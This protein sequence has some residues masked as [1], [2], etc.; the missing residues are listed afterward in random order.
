MPIQ[1]QSLTG[2][3]LADEMGL[4]KT[5]EILA[6]IVI[7]RRSGEFT[8]LKA[9]EEEANKKIV[10]TK[11]IMFSCVCGNK[12]ENFIE[13]VE[14]QSLRDIYQCILCKLWMHNKCVNYSGSR[15]TFI[16]LPC[17]DKIPPISSSCTLIVTPSIISS[18]WIEEI[19]KHLNK[20]LNILFYN[21]AMRG[22]IQPRD[23]A[24]LDICITTYDVLNDELAHVFAIENAKVLR[25]PKRFMI[26]P[27][28]LLYVEWWRICLD[29]A[30]M[31]HSTNSR[32][33]DMANRLN[34]INRWCITG[35]PI[36]RS[37]SDLN[38]LFSFIRQ[39]PF[40][41]KRW[42]E[43]ALLKPFYKNEKAPMAL[44]VSKVLWRT[45]KKFVE[46]QIN[47]PP[48]TEKTYWLNFSSFEQHLYE[49]VREK[50]REL[51]TN[52][53]RTGRDTPL[54]PRE[55]KRE[56]SILDF[57]PNM[58][59]DEFDHREIDLILSPLLNL[60]LTC[61]HPQ[62]IL[63][64]SDFMNQPKELKDKLLTME[65]SL[66]LLLKKTKTEAENIYRLIANDSNGIA[67]I[68]ISQNKVYKRD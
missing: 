26:I 39:E 48:Q 21:G 60:R 57:N 29:E 58:R 6:C 15:E 11:T 36:G 42:F 67:G 52:G 63:R 5:L 25:Q 66:E 41:E 31:V 47:L 28:P 40:C 7:N 2:G 55:A 56:R 8:N 54:S 37:L 44:E 19:N 24:K 32:C 13:Q 16:C 30:Q 45:T 35:T 53:F 4:G 18:Q 34:A 17:H 1:Q 27:S 22:F 65:K 20:K 12:P 68:N 23:L 38:G 33:A 43:E 9:I 59:L 10:K 49:R 61:N 46:D 50:F 64:K 62:L 3:I 14:K 51:R